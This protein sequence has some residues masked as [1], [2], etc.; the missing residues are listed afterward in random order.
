MQAVVK[1]RRLNG[2]LSI[3]LPLA[4]GACLVVL[5]QTQ[6]LHCT[7]SGG[8]LCP[9]LA[10]PDRIHPGGQCVRCNGQRAG[11]RSVA[12]LGLALGSLLGYLIAVVATVFPKWG[13]GGLSVVSAF[14][15]IPIVALSPVIITGPAT[16]P[17][18]PVSAA[19]S[20]RCW[21]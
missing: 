21:W 17:M 2:V 10:H 1:H 19:P 8:H 4:F 7:S 16:C 12:V 18:R 15:A 3:L 11:H 20:P 5:W 13:A 14:N 6:L 9:S